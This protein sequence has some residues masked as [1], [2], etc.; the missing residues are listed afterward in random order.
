MVLS[1]GL[2][3]LLTTVSTQVPAAAPE[4][5]PATALPLT[6]QILLPSYSWDIVGGRLS[7]RRAAGRRPPVLLEDSL[8]A[9]GLAGL[10]TESAEATVLATRAHRELEWG[11]SLKYSGLLGALAGV[12]CISIGAA[13][14]TDGSAQ[15][16]LGSGGGA[17]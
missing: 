14:S 7:V 8:T 5:T 3:A 1:A 6:E 13:Q 9:G 12:V 17:L 4:A 15:V 11:Y 2:L 10:V 16:A